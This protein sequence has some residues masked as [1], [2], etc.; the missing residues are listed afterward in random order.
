MGP[1][2]GPAVDAGS[3]QTAKGKVH[4]SAVQEVLGSQPS[5]HVVVEGYI[6]DA[7]ITIVP[8]VLAPYTH[9]GHT[10]LRYPRSHLGIVEVGDNPVPA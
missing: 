4:K 6:G 2:V 3:R 9:Y 10:C 1:I 8:A 7:R 5:Y